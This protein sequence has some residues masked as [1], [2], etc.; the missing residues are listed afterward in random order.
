MKEGC[1]KGDRIE[2]EVSNAY[3]NLLGGIPEKKKRDV[4]W[5]RQFLG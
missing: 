4:K 5:G 3:A 2:S 1:K